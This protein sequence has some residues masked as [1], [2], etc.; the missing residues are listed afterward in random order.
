MPLCHTPTC[1]TQKH[2]AHVQKKRQKYKWPP[3]T[4]CHMLHKHIL[5]NSIL[6][7]GIPLITHVNLCSWC[8]FGSFHFGVFVKRLCFLWFYPVV[9]SQAF[10]WNHFLNSI[11]RKAFIGGSKRWNCSTALLFKENVSTLVVVFFYSFLFVHRITSLKFTQ[12]CFTTIFVYIKPS[13]KH[14]QVIKHAQLAWLRCCE[15]WLW[16]FWENEGVFVPF[17]PILFFPRCLTWN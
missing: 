5:L 4:C 15:I 17:L 1:F 11:S 10:S 9:L 7:S 3:K 14:N 16:V 2:R 6:P 13:T 8:V 12:R